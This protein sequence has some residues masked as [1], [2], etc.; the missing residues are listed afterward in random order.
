MPHSLTVLG[1]IPDGDM[2]DVCGVEIEKDA[3]G[4]TFTTASEDDMRRLKRILAAE[5][6]EKIT[7]EH[8]EKS[9]TAF[10]TAAHPYF[11]PEERCEILEAARTAVSKTP[12]AVRTEF[13]E[14]RLYHFLSHSSV[15]SLEGFVKF[16]LKEYTALLKKAATA[17]VDV[18]LA[19]KEY[20]EFITL[21]QLFISTRESGIAAIHV[22]CAD[23][24]YVLFSESGEKLPESFD[25]DFWGDAPLTED[26]RLLST[27]LT[28]VPQ[29][30]I[31][32]GPLDIWNVR[33]LHT[34]MQVFEGRV[35]LC[36]TC[37]LCKN[38][39]L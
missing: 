19:E 37:A 34:V 30:V 20:A 26:D 13:I 39:R 15:L 38:P 28:L 16:R 9:L 14:R 24:Q 31:F 33:L 2:P 3:D 11:L 25:E 29:R 8:E 5:M 4:V 7:K 18:Y 36:H 21:L 17:A 35:H 1:H 22:L 23:G 32:H 6:A 10:I 12:P 27:L